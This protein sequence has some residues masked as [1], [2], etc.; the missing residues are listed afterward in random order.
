M[1]SAAPSMTFIYDYKFPLKKTRRIER[2]RFN[3][4]ISTSIPMLNILHHFVNGSFVPSS[5]FGCFEFFLTLSA[6]MDF[7]AMCLSM[8]T[9]IFWRWIAVATYITRIRTFSRME[10]VDML[11]QSPW[12][13]KSS[14]TFL[15]LMW[16]LFAMHLHI[17]LLTSVLCFEWFSAYRT[18]KWQFARMWSHMDYLKYTKRIKR[19]EIWTWKNC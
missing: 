3:F 18:E 12:C 10:W 11:F 15:T 9:Q 5:C 8:F 19:W 6:L 17:V 16:L 2:Q 4:F 13:N 7:F 14:T 1:S